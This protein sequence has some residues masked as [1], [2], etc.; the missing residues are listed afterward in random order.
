MG[1]GDHFAFIDSLSRPSFRR[2]HFERSMDAVAIMVYRVPLQNPAAVILSF[3]GSATSFGE[4]QV[5]FILDMVRIS[6]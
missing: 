5:G 3:P 1:N 6:F 2:V 4:P